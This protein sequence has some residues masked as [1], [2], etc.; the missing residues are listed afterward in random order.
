MFV[1]VCV[2]ICKYIY[3]YIFFSEG[4]IKFCL[5]RHK[6]CMLLVKKSFNIEWFLKIL[7]FVEVSIQFEKSKITTEFRNSNLATLIWNLRSENFR[8]VYNLILIKN[9][10]YSIEDWEFVYKYCCFVF[11]YTYI[12]FVFIQYA[13]FVH[14]H[15]LY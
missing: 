9:H 13:Q 5:I 3:I 12:F 4:K 2:Q 7:D 8:S 14:I 15:K 11:V 6:H 10:F 1:C